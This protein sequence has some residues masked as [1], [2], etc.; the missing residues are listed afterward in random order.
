MKKTLIVVA[1]LVSVATPVLAAPA[2]HRAPVNQDTSV[3]NGPYAAYDQSPA[4]NHN[5]A[6]LGSRV[7]GEDPDPGIRSQLIRDYAVHAG[8]GSE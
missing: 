7:V 6:A 4:Q 2:A 8:G 3:M 1:T 5:V